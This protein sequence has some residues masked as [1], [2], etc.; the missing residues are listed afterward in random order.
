MG[1][2][3]TLGPRYTGRGDGTLGEI[4]NGCVELKQWFHSPMGQVDCPDSVSA[5]LGRAGTSG[6]SQ[7]V[8]YVRRAFKCTLQ[9]RPYF[10][11]PPFL[12]S[13]LPGTPS[14]LSSMPAPLLP[15]GINTAST[16][17]QR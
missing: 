16:S 7:G 3:R 10:R 1:F 11:F 5:Y 4:R 2:D 14:R 8:R 9:V 12:G 15:Q 17:G 6:A 13:T